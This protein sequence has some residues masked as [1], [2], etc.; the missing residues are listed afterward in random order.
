MSRS[1]GRIISTLP[2][3][4]ASTERAEC[5]PAPATWRSAPSSNATA[6]GV[7]S[8][9]RAVQ[10][11]AREGLTQSTSTLGRIALASLELD[12]LRP[13]SSRYRCR[14]VAADRA[15]RRV[16]AAGPLPVHQRQS[17]GAHS[18]HTVAQQTSIQT[19]NYRYQPRVAVT[20][21]IQQHSSTSS[22]MHR[23]SNAH[24]LT[25]YKRCSTHGRS[26]VRKCSK[27]RNVPSP[28]GR[29]T[30]RPR[31]QNTRQY[32]RCTKKSGKKA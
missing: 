8:A 19:Q 30:E 28:T 25:T 13:R 27:R 16:P 14:T 12:S 29:T 2:H 9:A 11:V 4:V 24:Q 22:R 1:F 18:P 17:S 23:R 20:R 26:R 21:Q 7:L 32:Q 3:D 15:S 5:G 31:P 10:M 6:G